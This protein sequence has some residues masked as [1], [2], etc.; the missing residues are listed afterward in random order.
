MD[1][2]RT[3]PQ[4]KSLLQDSQ[5]LNGNSLVSESTPNIHREALASNANQKDLE[6]KS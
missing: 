4:T 1:E 3:S 6:N 2:D 5:Q